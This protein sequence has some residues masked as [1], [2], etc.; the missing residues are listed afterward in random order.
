MD[1]IDSHMKSFN[2]WWQQRWNDSKSVASVKWNAAYAYLIHI[3]TYLLRFARNIE[4]MERFFQL[5]Q[6]FQKLHNLLT[7]Q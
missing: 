3:E 2:I 6:L 1:R 5:F 4:Y 7:N